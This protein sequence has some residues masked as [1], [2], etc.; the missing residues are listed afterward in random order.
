MRRFYEPF[1][2]FRYLIGKKKS[3]IALITF[4]CLAGVAVGVMT[5]IIV[6][7]VMDGFEKDLK[8]K[9]LGVNPHIFVFDVLGKGVINYAELV[10]QISAFKKEGIV[11]CSPFVEGQAI[12]C[13][14]HLTRGVIL[15]GVDPELEGKVTDFHKNIVE[16]ALS[17][18][19]DEIVIGSELSKV[20]GVRIGDVI[21]VV[22][23]PSNSTGS[24]LLTRTRFTPKIRRFRISGIFKSGMYEY[25]LNLAFTSLEGAQALFGLDG[26]VT[27]IQVRLR[28]FYLSDRISSLLQK[29]LGFKFWVRTWQEMNRSLF[30]ALKL[31]KVVTFII[32]ILIVVVSVFNIVSTLM[33]MAM[34][35]IKEI[36]VLRAL[37]VT[38]RGIMRIFMYKGIIIGLTGTFIG[39]VFGVCTC[40]LLARYRFI[41]LPGDIY[42]IDTLPVS[43]N[44][45]DV[46]LIC[47]ASIILSL[48][49]TL[50]PAYYAARLNPIEALRYE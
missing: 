11:G 25:D 36:G 40:F 12:L 10:D 20:L 43:I 44:L 3:F 15:R 9:I 33:M 34:E 7:A 37:G 30:S 46:T 4:F 49:A 32:L 27:G 18:K 2:A 17:F 21:L 35:K 26:S 6:L 1:I 39:L 31:E 38:S 5:L 13:T 14:P 22:F 50:Y 41:E 42:Y 16:G 24:D 23:P 28:D 19:R 8:S 45:L 29:H 48:L 47:T